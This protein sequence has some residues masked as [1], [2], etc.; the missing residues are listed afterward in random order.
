MLRRPGVVSDLPEDAVGFNSD[1]ADA[2]SVGAEANREIQ[3]RAWLSGNSVN[4]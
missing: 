3:V 4:I 2:T 1:V